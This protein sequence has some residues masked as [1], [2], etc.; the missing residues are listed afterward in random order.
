MNILIIGNF[1]FDVLILKGKNNDFYKKKKQ[2]KTSQLNY[3][4]K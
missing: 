4:F 1:E 3:Y 2:I